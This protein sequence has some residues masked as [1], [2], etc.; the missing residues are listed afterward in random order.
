[1]AKVEFGGITGHVAFD[2]L[3]RRRNYQLD[4]LEQRGDREPA[5]VTPLT[6]ITTQH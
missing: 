3:G 1:M 6:C 5:K 4:V 2:S